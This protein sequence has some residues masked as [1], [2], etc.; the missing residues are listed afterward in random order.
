M[1]QPAPKLSDIS[2]EDLVNDPY[3]AFARIRTLGS[4]V[5]VDSTRIHLVTRFKDIM[6]VERNHDRFASTNPQSLM[7]RV[8]GHSLMR[9]DDTAHKQERAA[10]AASFHPDMVQNHW[11][12]RFH[13]IASG[14]I[15][16]FAANR[17]TD[18]F[19][20]YAAPM[21]ALSL[22]DL[23]G[24]DHVAWEDIAWWSQALMDAVGNYQADPVLFARG[25]QASDAIDAAIDRVLARHRAER[26]PSILSSMVHAEHPQSLEQI[27]ANVK[28]I[29]GGGL[30]EP[31]DSILTL[32]M[33]LLQNPDQLAQVLSDPTLYP[34]A[35]EESVRWVAPIG[36]YPRRV[37]RDT[38][39]GDTE[40]EEDDQIGICVGAANRDPSRFTDPDRFDINRPRRQHLGFGSGPHFCAGTWIARKMVGDIA[41][42]LLFERLKRLR[43]NPNQTPIQKGW[44][45]RGPASLPVVWGS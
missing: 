6:E 17:E 2:I 24:F 9:K 3:P 35:F 22:I 5:W 36:M 37:T 43:L 14:L 45:F 8:M 23:L 11:A 19:S 29:I 20:A 38:V 7:N 44:V 21:A 42:P 12:S 39:L 26:N 41:V 34:T 4:A 10:M 15:D 16:Q 27:R 25:E 28:V 32:V 13:T 18:L 33:G 40:L 30:N 1:A 31:R